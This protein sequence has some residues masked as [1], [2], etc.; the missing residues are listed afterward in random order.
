MP[1]SFIE[2]FFEGMNEKIYFLLVIATQF[3]FIFQG[4]DLAESGAHAVFYQRFFSDPGS[5]QASF[6]YW[7]SGLTGALWLKYFPGEGL[8]GLR[9]AGIIVTTCTFLVT[10]RLLKHFLKTGPLRLGLYM[11]I[12]LLGTTVQELNY[13]DLGSF[14][15][16]F[17]A[18]FLISGLSGE[19]NSR[20]VIS[21]FSVAIVSLVR[22][23]NVCGLVLLLVIL[24][25]GVLYRQPVRRVFGHTLLFVAGFAGGLAG[26]YLLM[27][28]LH[29]DQMFFQ[30]LRDT[31]RMERHSQNPEGLIP[32]AKIYLRQYGVALV[33]AVTGLVGLWSFAAAW[34]RLRTEVS[35]SRPLLPLLKYTLLFILTILCLYLSWSNA[36]FW[37]DLFL[38]YAGTSLIVG[39]LIVTGQ[40][41]QDMRL[42]AATGCLLLLVIPAGQPT[43]LM[44]AGKYAVWIALPVTVDYL[45]NIRSLSSSI[46]IS[47]N[48]RYSYDQLI[49]PEEMQGLRNGFI[50]L[51]LVYVLSVSYFY[52]YSDRSNRV[53][54]RYKL[55]VPQA[56]AIYTT[57]ERSRAI[58]ELLTETGKYVKPDD[59]VLGYDCL[60]IYYYLTG[61]RP[62]MH[63]SWTGGYD[64]TVFRQVLAESIRET[65]ICPVVIEQKADAAAR[66]WKI[67]NDRESP[68]HRQTLAYLHA[69][70]DQYNYR[71][72]WENDIFRVYLPAEKNI[73]P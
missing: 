52:P 73:S 51:T 44:A 23:P 60:P 33:S 25:S 22:V 47:E 8:L 15:F 58:G 59:Y 24:F 66:T 35:W 46:V 34:K 12:L 2:D 38:F 55:S 49:P 68:T 57:Q 5:V 48:R 14:G 28:A 26:M 62:Y 31:W 17:A 19:K 18:A 71:L 56:G 63:S 3:L 21:G 72:A 10:Y 16:A 11:I 32:S 50:F 61:A 36:D 9:I 29:H 67:D 54:M 65:R 70:L 64:S 39:F 13:E 45:L 37:F 20:L 30:S 43:A 6:M 4:L 69:F 7:F 40:H 53:A 42:L 1:K 27:R 41:P